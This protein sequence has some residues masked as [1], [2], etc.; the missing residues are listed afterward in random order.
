MLAVFAPCKRAAPYLE[1]EIISAG[2]MALVQR[3][4]VRDGFSAVLW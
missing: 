4:A 2:S 1:S 3:G